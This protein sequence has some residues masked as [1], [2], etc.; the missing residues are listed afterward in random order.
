[1]NAPPAEPD[2]AEVQ[3]LVV[4]SYAL[5]R[6]RHFVLQVRDPA[7][8]RD[9]LAGLA[10]GGLITNASLDNIGVQSLKKDGICPLNIGFSYRGLEKLE[11]PEPYLRVFQEK[12]K[13]YAEG[14]YL[15][16]AR[17]LA[18]TGPSAAERWE[19]CFKLDR[20]HVLLTMHADEDRELDV[21]AEALEKKMPG[22]AGLD[23]WQTPLEGRHLTTNSKKR[24]VH[25]G[26]RDGI[27]DP[28]IRGFHEERAWHDGS[29]RL[30]LHAPG[31]FLLGYRN[32]DQFN[33]WLL[34]NPS[35]RPNPWLLPLNPAP[36]LAEFFRDGSFAALRKMEQ[37][38]RAFRD[39]VARWA[40]KRGVS[41]EYVR[42][43]L[44][45]RWDNGRVVKPGE[46]Q[47]P[48][49][50][51]PDDPAEL[52][53]FDFADD[54]RGEGCPFGSHIRRMNP[55]TD[56]VVPA[57]SRSLIRRSMPY[58]PSY[59][60]NEPGNGPRRGLLGLF[61]CASLEDQFEHLLVEWGNANPMGP[62]NLG[63][64]K[65]PL[66]GN[67][68]NPAAVFDIPM[69]DEKL[70]QLDGFR[71][72]VTTCGTLYAFFPSLTALGRIA[73]RGRPAP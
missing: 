73:R 32:D 1:M 8:A 59:K 57:R 49:S 44:G 45:G 17:R 19:E 51:E 66:I 3:R 25:F 23:G 35:P 27:S 21:F 13:A 54:P 40:V 68:E 16:A 62:R 60:E 7:K 20:A 43:K 26:L 31:E 18:D 56:E 69:K 15:R 42:A 38:E 39:F 36:G 67:H 4:Y 29:R 48:S 61:F 64:A 47:A 12:A 58:G 71:P 11:L 41:E 14:A 33:P 70:R 46:E 22:A 30:K 65:D 6:C 63:N 50:P 9:F 5:N 72:F 34:I 2:K 10:A 37:H 52:D 28:A 55:R 53:E 24:T